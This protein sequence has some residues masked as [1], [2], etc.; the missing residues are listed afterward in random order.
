MAIVTVHRCTGILLLIVSA[1][2]GLTVGNGM[3]AGQGE[4][5]G[6]V[7]FQRAAAILPVAWGMTI[8]TILSK[9][10]GMMVGVAVDATDAN[11]I[12]HRILV[13]SDTLCRRMRS[14]QLKAGNRMIKGQ[15]VAHFRP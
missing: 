2:A 11:M 9:L 6:C 8:L 12:E 1:V 13:T 15:R 3:S 4:S 7:Q 10:A 5:I 14:D